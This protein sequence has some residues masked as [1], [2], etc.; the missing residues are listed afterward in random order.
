[1]FTVRYERKFHVQFR[2]TSYLTGGSAIRNVSVLMTPVHQIMGFRT[3]IRKTF[4]TDPKKLFII[5]F[6]VKTEEK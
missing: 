6:L 1:M 4:S 3:K 2:W 5:R